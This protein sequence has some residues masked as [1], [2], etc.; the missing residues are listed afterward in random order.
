MGVSVVY[1]IGLFSK[2]NKVTIKTLRYYD[3]VGLLKNIADIFEGRKREL[4]AAIE[5]SKQQ[6]AQITH[7]L[8]KMEEGFSMNYEVALKE[9]SEVIVY[10]KRMG[11][12]AA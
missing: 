4:E 2:I 6:L 12:D 8:E 9:L 7:Y 3:E 10:S 1:R 11:I 5:E